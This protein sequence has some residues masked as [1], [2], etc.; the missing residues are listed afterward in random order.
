[1]SDVDVWLSDPTPLDRKSAAQQ[2]FEELRDLIRSGRVQPGTRLPSEAQMAA[3]YAVSRPV[4]REALRSLNAL[5]LTQTRTG[6]GTFVVGAGGDL[7]F[8][9]Y[10]AAD[11]MEA[12]PFVEIP[13]AGWAALRRSDAE[14]AR[15]TA[16][17][18]RMDAEEDP[19]AWVQLD[20]DFHASIAEA[21]KNAIFAKVVHDVRDALRGQSGWLNLQG[22][23]RDASN[24]EHRVILEA[25]A[26]GSETEART[27]MEAHLR[28]VES[29]VARIAATAG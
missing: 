16:L 27:A 25:I 26:R 10:A 17:C 13:A 29:T 23:R 14:L 20:S 6:S 3:R 18:D 21:S 24:R 19:E 12:R 11:L 1:M 15:L 5:G 7:R 9:G 28:Q 4:I 2:V 8:G 22:P